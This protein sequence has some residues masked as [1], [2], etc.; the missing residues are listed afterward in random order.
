[1]TKPSKTNVGNALILQKWRTV[2]LK[3]WR[4]PDRS[5]IAQPAVLHHVRDGA[6]PEHWL[7]R[8]LIHWIIQP[9][10]SY[11]ILLVSQKLPERVA[12]NCVFFYFLFDLLL[13]HLNR[14]VHN[15]HTHK[16][17]YNVCILYMAY[18]DN[19]QC[20]PVARMSR[21][22]LMPNLIK[23]THINVNNFKILQ[24]LPLSSN[25]K[26]L[27]RGVRGKRRFALP[28]TRFPPHIRHHVEH[29]RHCCS[30][31]GLVTSAKWV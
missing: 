14:Y 5:T 7:L 17:T 31:E 6:S 1:M 13:T 30:F 24:M 18:I 27:C 26:V 15:T 23:F 3:T 10:P 19:I 29:S 12:K 16:H 2:T 8:I 4:A 11:I 22:Q 20:S 28:H 25:L 9:Y 21:N